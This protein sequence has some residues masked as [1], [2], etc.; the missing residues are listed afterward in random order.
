MGF[1]EA[2]D[3]ELIHTKFLRRVLCV[4]KSTNISALYGALGRLPLSVIR[5]LDII[6]YWIKIL[7]QNNSSLV[8]NVY[9]MLK[10]DAETHCNYNDK[11]WAF[12]I[13]DMLQKLGLGF[14]L[15]LQVHIEYHYINKAKTNR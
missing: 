12:Q 14:V 9:L 3:I 11:N 5:K 1:H 10:E 15:D 13:K 7:N 6:K 8:K 4:R 2:T